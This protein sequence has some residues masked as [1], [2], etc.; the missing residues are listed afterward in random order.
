MTLSGCAFCRHTAG[1]SPGHCAAF[2]EDKRIPFEILDGDF[3]HR[4]KHPDD[5]GIQFEFRDNATEGSIARRW[6]NEHWL[7]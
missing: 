2:P 7:E 1:F 6:V 3:N 5:N 4:F